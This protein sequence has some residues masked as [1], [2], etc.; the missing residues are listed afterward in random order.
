MIS[1]AVLSFDARTENPRLTI[2]IR[3]EESD[4]AGVEVF[5]FDAEM[6]REPSLLTMRAARALV[7]QLDEGWK[8]DTWLDFAQ[9]FELVVTAPLTSLSHWQTLRSRLEDVSRIRGIAMRAMSVQYATIKVTYLGTVQ[10]L[11]T[12]LAQRGLELLDHEGYWLLRQP[13]G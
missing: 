2:T 3:N 7:R 5:Q 10:Q 12:A 13:A 4:D 11:Q 9:Q 6:Q 1:D 8:R